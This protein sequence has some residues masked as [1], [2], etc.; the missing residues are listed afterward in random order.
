M[1]GEEMRAADVGH[2]TGLQTGCVHIP[3]EFFQQLGYA[4]GEDRVV[5]NAGHD[6][7]LAVGES[8][9]CVKPVLG[10]RDRIEPGEVHDG[11]LG[12]LAEQHKALG[13]GND[14]GGVQSLPDILD[15]GSFVSG[16][17]K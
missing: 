7:V 9:C 3:Q 8:C 13:V 5:A 6:D 11:G 15:E 2:T 14:F 4:A 12:G 1:V 10:W 17:L 16:I